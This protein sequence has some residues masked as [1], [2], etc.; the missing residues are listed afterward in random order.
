MKN[1]EKSKICRYLL[2]KDRILIF[3]VGWLAGTLLDAT[4]G[5]P[6]KGFILYVLYP[7]RLNFTIVPNPFPEDSYIKIELKNV[8]DL[9][10]SNFFVYYQIAC[11]MNNSRLATLS[12]QILY[13][14]E[15][16]IIRIQAKGINTSCSPITKPLIVR[17]YVDDLGRC[18]NEFVQG[19]SEVCMYC[20]ILL[21]I[22]AKEFEG[23]KV[24]KKKFEIWYPFFPGK[25]IFEASPKSCLPIEKA[26]NMSSLKLVKELRFL[27][28][29]A[30]TYCLKGNDPNWCQAYGFLKPPT[31]REIP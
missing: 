21:N 2:R 30:S 11:T 23:G 29:D 6:L 17:F 16:S 19:T 3:F 14:G 25:L 13:P 31:V 9:P 8:G 28:F 20:R 12:K 26:Q 4:I 18:Y 10:L 1:F 27:V 7:P 5:N 24:L 15:S 22:S